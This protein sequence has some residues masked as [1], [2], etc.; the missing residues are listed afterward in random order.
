MLELDRNS[1]NSDEARDLERVG[2]ALANAAGEAILP[3]F[4]GSDLDTVSKEIE[5]YDPVTNADRA[6]ERAMRNVLTTLR[7]QDGVLGEEF[8]TLASESGLTWVLDPIDGTRGFVSGTPT[9][10]T[11]IALSD[12]QGPFWNYRSTL[13]QRAVC[14]GFLGRLSPL[15]L[16][17]NAP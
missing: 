2:Y 8:G 15:G 3:Y 6:A 5:R 14:W 1:I 12:E 10:G 9:W 11:L 4:R 16:W 7:P 17:G 13:Y